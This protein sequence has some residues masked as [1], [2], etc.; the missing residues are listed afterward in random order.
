M[1]RESTDYRRGSEKINVEEEESNLRGE[2][3]DAIRKYS[4]YCG[5]L[6]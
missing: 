3:R 4:Y 6:C 1:I 2:E 5:D